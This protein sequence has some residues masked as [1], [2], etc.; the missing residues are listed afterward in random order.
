MYFSNCYC[1][2]DTL[3]S[4]FIN[5]EFYVLQITV[6]LS[7]TVGK[8]QRLMLCISVASLHMLFLL[9]LHFAYHKVVEGK[10]VKIFYRSNL[11]GWCFIR[12]SPGPAHSFCG[13]RRNFCYSRISTLGPF[14]I[15]PSDCP[16][17]LDKLA[18]SFPALGSF[19]LK[20]KILVYF[21]LSCKSKSCSENRWKIKPF[22]NTLQKNVVNLA[23]YELILNV[24]FKE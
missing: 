15:P 17:D 18:T 9:Y 12:A 3:W 13:S 1:D 14:Y 4:T 8:S 10:R 7:R 16:F 23:W 24:Q 22:Y 19:F 5:K 11:S 2:V 21:V 6:L 20:H